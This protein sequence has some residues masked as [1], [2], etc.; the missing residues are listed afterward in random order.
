MTKKANTTKQT[1]AQT[2]KTCSST[3]EVIHG[4]AKYCSPEC[5]P[6]MRAKKKTHTTTE[7]FW[8]EVRKDRHEQ[9]LEIMRANPEMKYDD[10]QLFN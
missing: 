6:A 1:K 2:C 4:N 8:K 10:I 7:D 5:R 3:F 9:K